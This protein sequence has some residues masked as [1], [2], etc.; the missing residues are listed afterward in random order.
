M[1]QDEES[2]PTSGSWRRSF[3]ITLMVLILG[4]LAWWFL[5]GAG[6]QIL[7]DILSS[8][9]DPSP[10]AINTS[11]QP[12]PTALPDEQQQ[13]QEG[14]EALASALE[15]SRQQFESQLASLDEFAR[16]EDLADLRGEI[17]RVRESFPEGTELAKSQIH[18]SWHLLQL[19]EIEFRL[20]GDKEA[21]LALLSRIRN[22]LGENTEA[23]DILVDLGTLAREIE[24]SKESGL[25]EQLNE[26]RAIEQLA[27]EVPLAASEF[28]IASTA[29]QGFLSRVSSGLRSLVRIER[30]SSAD[31]IQDINRLQLLF[32]CQ[33]MQVAALRRDAGSLHSER[34]LAADWIQRHAE[35]N[36]PLAKE[37]LSR[38][39]A[40]R[41]LNQE[42]VLVDFTAP[43]T[44]L[45]DMA[46]R[47]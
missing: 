9:E 4:A 29:P 32:M 3:L 24:E 14:V 16:V 2:Q 10:G 38:L 7:S 18:L 43:L 47:E 26:L 46:G 23:I 22:L 27:V 33:R 28:R 13:R 40:L 25:L 30:R 1:N 31:E 5:M 12:D 6:N 41:Q 45:A 39:D 36:D 17:Q 21:V 20:L 44:R 34:E 19:A 42:F 15:S 35:S 8:G 11:Q 37:L